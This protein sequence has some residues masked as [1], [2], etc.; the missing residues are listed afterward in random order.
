MGHVILFSELERARPAR[1]RGPLPEGGATISLFL[2]VRYDRAPTVRQAVALAE[3]AL[4]ECEVRSEGEA[5]LALP[6]PAQSD[7]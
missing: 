5:Q 2:G 3:S 1:M 6:A 7:E 4:T